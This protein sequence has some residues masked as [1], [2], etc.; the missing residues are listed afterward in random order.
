MAPEGLKFIVPICAAAVLSLLF[1]GPGWPA[2]A[3]AA[4]AFLVGLFFRLPAPPPEADGAVILSPAGGF[5]IEIVEE[6][7]P[8]FLKEMARR[9]SIFMTPLDVHINTAPM[10]GTVRHTDY[11]PGAFF[12]ADRPEA[13]L[14]NERMS[15]GIERP[16]GVKCLAHQV[17]GW[18]A[19]RIV[20]DVSVGDRV[21]RGR[22]YGLIQFGSR[23]DLY[24][25]VRADIRVKPGEHVR[26]ARTVLAS[27]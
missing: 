19:R 22:R 8:V 15:V 10:D 5:V 23:M 12:K 26:A 20:C 24:L 14:H 27:V 6:E 25:P 13:R 11:R 18:L 21:E 4:A 16:D 7:E 1:I 17:A 9:I 2:T 3:C